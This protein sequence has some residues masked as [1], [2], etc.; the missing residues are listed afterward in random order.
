MMKA[1][2]Y[3]LLGSS[4]V[5]HLVFGLSGQQQPQGLGPQALWPTAVVVK[6]IQGERRVNDPLAAQIRMGLQDG[7]DFFFFE[8][9]S[10][11]GGATAKAG[12]RLYK[13]L[14]ASLLTYFRD[15]LRNPKITDRLIVKIEESWAV[16]QA[17]AVR[18]RP[19]IHLGVALTGTYYVECG[20]TSAGADQ[21]R[22][23]T[24]LEDP[25][26]P[27]ADSDLPE[28]LRR[29]LG[30]GA[31]Q[32]FSLPSGSVLLHPP[33]LVHA[34]DLD[35]DLGLDAAPRISISFTADIQLRPAAAAAPQPRRVDGDL[36]EL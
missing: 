17:R 6:Q 34:S 25:R 3:M 13:F 32:R 26:P 5:L 16:V 27:A 7:G 2:V 36:D 22:C 23:D 19:H 10:R 14:E 28:V 24:T 35:S 4:Q 15:A 1:L 21:A 29:K 33:W 11:I 31:A 18:Q 20:N 8:Q 12:R 30:F 9:C